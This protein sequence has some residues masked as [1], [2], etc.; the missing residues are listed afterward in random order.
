MIQEL[1]ELTEKK[2]SLLKELQ[3]S[4]DYSKCDYH[5]YRDH[6]E[7]KP[8]YFLHDLRNNVIVASGPLA[9]I[10]SFMSIRS[11]KKADI[12]TTIKL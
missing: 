7:S 3:R 10:Q 12:Y 8:Y 5:L 1:I 9:R 2:L 11:I 6:K 4:Q